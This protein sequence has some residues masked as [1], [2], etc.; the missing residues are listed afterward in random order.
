M[1]YTCV[2][3]KVDIVFSRNVKLKPEL[4][5]RQFYSFA[6]TRQRT[7]IEPQGPVKIRKIFRSP[8]LDGV[9]TQNIQ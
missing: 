5:T 8:C 3:E 6:T 2:Q 4:G 9:A 1:L 7:V